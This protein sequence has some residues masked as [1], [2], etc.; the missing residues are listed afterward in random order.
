MSTVYRRLE[1]ASMGAELWSGAGLTLTGIYL[2]FF[3]PSTAVPTVLWLESLRPWGAVAAFLVGVTHLVAALEPPTYAT[4]RVRK[5]AAALSLPF[6]GLWI[7]SIFQLGGE[8]TGLTM[9]VNL[10]LL[11]ISITRRVYI[12]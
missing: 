5:I 4:I 7:Y 1:R 11:I 6:W 8:A 10:A 12:N 2:Y 9:V 3:Y